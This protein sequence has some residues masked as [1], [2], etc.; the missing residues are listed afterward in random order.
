MTAV[1]NAAA[2]SADRRLAVLQRRTP[3]GPRS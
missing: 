3:D 1:W 2:M